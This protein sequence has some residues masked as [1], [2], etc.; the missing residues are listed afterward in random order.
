MLT[1][2]WFPNA[3]RIF[4]QDKGEEENC[5]TVGAV[6]SFESGVSAISLLE[7]TAIGRRQVHWPCGIFGAYGLSDIILVPITDAMWL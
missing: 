2:T 5:P 6:S 1:V 3:F 7:L 4:E